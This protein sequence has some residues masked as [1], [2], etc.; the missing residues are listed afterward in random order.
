MLTHSTHSKRGWVVQERILSRRSLRFGPT[1]SWECWTTSRSEF[2]HDP[3]NSPE[4]SLSARF[5]DVVTHTRNAPD[6][7]RATAE[8]LSL[9]EA[10]VLEFTASQLTVPS[11]RYTA[12]SGLISAAVLSTGWRN[13]AGLWL[14][15]II[16]QLLWRRA[17]YDGN[18]QRTGLGP[19]W[20]WVSVEGS[21]DFRDKDTDRT[22]WVELAEVVT[23]DEKDTAL[24]PAVEESGTSQPVALRL[25]C[26]PL[27]CTIIKSIF[28][29]PEA[30][31]PW[32]AGYYV[33][34]KHDLGYGI[35]WDEN[36]VLV[37]LVG[38]EHG[39]LEG[40]KLQGIIVAP[41][42]QWPGA[43]ARVGR[44]QVY[45]HPRSGED[46]DPPCPHLD[47]YDASLRQEI[48]LV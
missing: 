28:L 4:H 19:S 43:Y 46:Y 16:D 41:S 27:K 38:I 20:S 13:L 25:S 34:S 12:I 21:V 26:N 3:L 37:P 39:K 32:P 6:T 42:T 7:A 15:G 18:T 35:D 31:P 33:E 45:V 10:I 5:L 36:S 11:D 22:G 44:A 47:L 17:P 29:H 30:W 9:W 14:P 24:V 48:L 40:G 2:V 23:D 8:I 1:L